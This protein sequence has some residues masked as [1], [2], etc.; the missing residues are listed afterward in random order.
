M[1][2]SPEITYPAQERLVAQIE[3]HTTPGANTYLDA[4]DL[5]DRLFG[6]HLM[7][8]MIVLGAAYQRGLLPVAAASI[9]RA[10][11]LNGVAIQRNREAFRVGRM[12]VIDP[13]WADA[14]VQ[15]RTITTR[16]VVSAAARAL[17]D[18][19]GAAGEVL[20]LL[21]IRVPELIAYQD[22]AYA[23]EYV[24]LVRRVARAEADA[25]P[26]SSRLT[27]AVARYL[28]KLMAYKDEYEVARLSLQP[29]LTATIAQQFGVGARRQYQLLPPFLRALGRRRKIG[30]GAWFDG[31]YHLLVRLRGL[32]R[33]PFDPFGRAPVRRVERALIG[34]YR[35]VIEAELATLTAGRIERAA[36]IAELPDMIR[37]YEEIKLRNVAR[38]RAALEQLVGAAGA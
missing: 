35:Q 1:V 22:E 2:R 8:N 21:E 36:A 37:G 12:V 10:I 6:D 3:Q 24:E 4:V 33:T 14:E 9:E 17:I 38:Y 5:A 16:P 7:A 15:R 18:A 32:R 26:G 28:F 20:R 25:L 19:V 31:I 30:L 11:E 29:E 27:E 23:R 13:T 34:E